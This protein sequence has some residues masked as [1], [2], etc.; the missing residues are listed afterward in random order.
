MSSA[1]IKVGQAEVH[2]IHTLQQI[3]PVYEREGI[4]KTHTIH[5]VLG[6]NSNVSLKRSP[7]KG[8]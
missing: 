7:C 4:L 8:L 3:S 1:G 6:T 5:A 2:K